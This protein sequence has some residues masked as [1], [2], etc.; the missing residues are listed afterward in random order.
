MAPPSESTAAK[1]LLLKAQR[2]PTLRQPNKASFSTEKKTRLFNAPGPKTSQG[3]AGSVD[4]TGDG[5]LGTVTNGRVACT[6]VGSDS[7]TF[8]LAQSTLVGMGGQPSA[9][10]VLDAMTQ[11]RG[12]SCEKTVDLNSTRSRMVRYKTIKMINKTAGGCLVMADQTRLL[13]CVHSSVGLP[14]M[15]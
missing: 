9:D 11:S 6:R 12:Q 5:L 2:D 4:G 1:S 3:F 14:M 13:I 7:M 10:S 8:A 15:L